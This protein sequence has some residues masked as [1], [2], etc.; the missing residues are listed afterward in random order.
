M[1]C[2]VMGVF[3]VS[4][5][6]SPTN[7]NNEKDTIK[8]TIGAAS[9]ISETVSGSTTETI[10]LT[11]VIRDFKASGTDGGHPDFQRTGSTCG[12]ATGI[13]ENT[14]VDGKPVYSGDVTCN[15]TSA[16]RFNQWYNDV[17]GVNQST[18]HE[19]VLEH[20]GGGTYTYSNNSYFPIDNDLFGNQGFDDGQGNSHNYHFTTEIHTTFTYTGGETFSFT[21]DDDVWV[22]INGDLVIDLGGIHT[23]ING[24]VNLDDLNLNEGEDYPLD[25]FQA[26]RQT[27]GSNFTFTTSLQLVSEP[28]TPENQDPVADA[29]SD[30]TLEATGPTTE[31][32]L[33]GSGSDDPDGDDLT[34]SWSNGDS[35]VSTTVNLGVGVHTFTLTVTDEQGATDSD[36]VSIEITDTTAP[37]ISF[38][39]QTN[40]LWP[41][42]HKMVL[43]AT[44]ISASDIVDGTTNVDVTVSSNEASNGRG[45]GNTDSDYEIVT[46]SDG[47]VDVYVRA[48]RSGKGNGRTYSITMSS[49]DNAGNTASESLEVSVA[50][51]QGRK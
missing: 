5:Q 15:T 42:N 19:F 45:D 40:S 47:S 20:Q 16:E 37:D 23:P 7:S 25:I 35:G 11:G 22:F 48:E 17:D 27:T 10:T 33:D 1:L 44:G 38:S 18:T 6:D 31:V 30:Q 8:D 43:V 2:L 36:E 46:N 39:Q 3:L 24:S 12:T 13:V 34:Y 49:S 21:G 26:E 14:L 28:P 51:S 29:G 41:P 32:S 9:G 4:C 50:K